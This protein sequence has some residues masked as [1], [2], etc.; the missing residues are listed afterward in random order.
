MKLLTVYGASDDL[1]EASGIKGE[2]E[3]NSYKSPYAG[4]LIVTS[5]SAKAKISIHCIYHGHWCFGIGPD[6]GDY[7]VM[8]DWTITRTWG[9]D[10]P[11][12]ETVKIEC[13]DDAVLKF[14]ENDK[15]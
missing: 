10:T 3:F 13:P 4:K 1:I 12:S 15:D 6:D 14:I 5:K 11:Y 8:P 2:D 9:E 7:D